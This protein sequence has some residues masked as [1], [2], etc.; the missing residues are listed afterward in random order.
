MSVI[1]RR[2]LLVTPGRGGIPLNPEDEEEEEGDDPPLPG[3]AGKRFRPSR[4]KKPL[5]KT[6]QVTSDKTYPAN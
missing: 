4:R 5:D 3:A 6:F 2:N 1:K